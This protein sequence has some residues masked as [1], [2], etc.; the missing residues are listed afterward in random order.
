MTEE[1]GGAKPFNDEDKI[2][3]FLAYFGILCLIPFLMFKDKRDDPQKE[4][5]YWHGR[6]GLGLTIVACVVWFVLMVGLFIPIVNI[7]VGLVLCCWWVVIL[8]MSIMG[9]VKA[10]GGT[11]W[12]IPGVSKIAEM[13]N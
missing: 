12:E 6:Q 1:V 9:W 7:L 11:K 5:V 4:F 2:H 3:L 8:A 13:F 10:F